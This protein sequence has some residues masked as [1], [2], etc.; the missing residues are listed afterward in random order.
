MG[1]AGLEQEERPPHV[2]LKRLGEGLSRD[3]PN[4][5]GHRVGGVVDQYVDAAVLAGRRISQTL[6]V[7]QIAHMGRYGERLAADGPYGGYRLV[8]G[9]G[10]AAGHHHRGALGSE[11]L[12]HRPTD[13]AATTRHHGHPAGQV[14]QRGNPISIQHGHAPSRT[15]GPTVL[16]HR[17]YPLPGRRGDRTT[18]GCSHR[19]GRRADRAW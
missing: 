4:G 6:Q 11:G 18:G 17:P 15:V 10:L 8:A 9:L 14:V 16:P 7:I 2:Y 3:L 19:P 1:Q 12:G 5:L 13:A